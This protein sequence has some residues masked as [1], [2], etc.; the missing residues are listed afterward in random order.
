MSDKASA[1]EKIVGVLGVIVV[2]GL[3]AIIVCL[4]FAIGDQRHGKYHD[5]VVAFYNHDFVYPP[6]KETVTVLARVSNVYGSPL[7]LVRRKDGSTMTVLYSDISPGEP[8]ND[9]SSGQ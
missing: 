2:F 1:G 8:L 7:L 4:I 3:V 6:T 5:K 9:L